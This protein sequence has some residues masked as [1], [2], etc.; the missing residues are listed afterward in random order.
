MFK[1]ML[2]GLFAHKLRLL[3]SALAIVLGTMFMSAAFVAGDT[4]AKGF[5]T[6]FATISE[7]LDVTV[8]A[9]K[10]TETFDS[11]I[12]TTFVP[13]AKADQIGAV[14]GVAKSTP[15][16]FSDGARVIDD[17]GKVVA[18]QGA[19]RFGA[20]W[21]GEE[22]LLELRSGR[23]P[24]APNE[25]AI[26]A[27]LAEANDFAVG[28]TVDII[29]LQPRQPFTVVGITGYEGDRDSLGGETTVFFTM[30]RA[31]ELML[32]ETG[33]YTS[34]DLLAADGVTPDALADRVRAA[35]GPG[36]DVKTGEQA[37]EEQASA[38]QTFVNFLKIGL[39]VFAVIGMIT[40][41]FLIFNTFSMLVAQ[42]TRELALY[43]SF[44][45]SRG[46]VN[47]SVLTE[48]VL[49]GLTASLVGLLL[50]IG[51][52]WL[53][54]TLVGQFGGDLPVSG[55]VVR[56]YVV[57]TTL[58]IGTLFTVVAAVV[59]AIRASRVAPIEAMR[60]AVTPDKPLLK[61][62]VAGVVLLAAGLLLL[63]LRFTEVIKGQLGLTLG[64]GAL[65]VFLGV[66]LLAPMLS[67]PVTRGLGALLG[68]R[69]PS[70]LGTSNTG[71]NPRRTA[72]TAVALMLGV[73]L[74]TAAGL[75][76]SSLKAGLTE[77]FSTDM[78]AQLV[79]SAGFTGS[80]QAGFDPALEQQ[81]QA[82][83]GVA[84]AAAVRA[85]FGR[86]AGGDAQL[87]SGDPVR[88]AELFTLSA[89]SGE[90]RPLT[91][92]EIII[93]SGTADRTGAK[94]GDSVSVTTAR[95]GEQQQKVV[96]IL[97]SSA[98][99]SGP[100][101]NSVDAAGFTSPLAQGGYVEV[102][103]GQDVN[104]VKE[105][106]DQLFADN[107]EMT[108]NNQQELIDQ[109]TSFLDILLTVLNVLL[110]LTILVAVL[111][112]INTL[113][114]SVYERTREI[115]LIRA[116]GLSRRST[117]WMIT[118][119]SVLISV[120]GALLGVIVGVGLGLAAVKILQGDFLKLTIP[121]GYLVTV[122]ILAIIA[123]VVAAILPAIRAARLNV[124]EAI[125]Y[126]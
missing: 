79:V 35:A 53:L 98:V 68:R 63:I 42:R 7:D 20:G 46:Q 102:A 107:P 60:S 37:A 6:L 44:G 91:A 59:P 21:A 81:M 30:P 76:A 34:V 74:A 61:L 55:V 58:L 66:V 115:G 120:F 119:E 13:Q 17:N 26:S 124:L 122:L 100:L 97:E 38:F 31:Q 45:A 109:S 125:A 71:R 33:V 25:V 36:F 103:D 90:I 123:G 3:L 5:S 116:I 83:P 105:R 23:A 73:A 4:I 111:G 51:V 75:F 96:A 9:T 48:A 8:T 54:K 62:T 19:P 40:G 16:V 2:R 118:V 49:L 89:T 84:T 64:G 85:D 27:N 99:M 93:D 101:L 52:G 56:P 121:W 67:R 24:T 113:L 14:D 18:T 88:L 106:L 82:I 11:P 15:Q 65:L 57:I 70:R 39:T 80:L 104:A 29:T 94:V 110:G 72:I 95:G 50:G 86:I 126:E 10:N 1:A 69:V 28:D 43:R 47:R 92:G 12:I 108:V 32:G 114:L 112:V 41:A 77:T 117:A 78:K 87:T 22:G